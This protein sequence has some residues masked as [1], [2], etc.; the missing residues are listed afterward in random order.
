MPRFP[1]PQL[2]GALALSMVLVAACSD[3]GAGEPT[4][5]PTAPPDATATSTVPP[6]ASVTA[7]AAPDGDRVEVAAPIVSVDVLIAESFPPQYFVE[8]VSA[9]PNG[10]HRFSRYE[11]TRSGTEIQIDV[12]NTFPAEDGDLACT[13]IYG[14]V[15]SNVAL[16]I[17]FEPGT[18]YTLQVNDVTKTFVAQ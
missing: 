15:T 12:Y 11:E 9:L 6:D 8:V 5:S 17:D 3:D 14:E 10:C 4:T 7:T 1:V 13:M 16:G 2:L 18:E